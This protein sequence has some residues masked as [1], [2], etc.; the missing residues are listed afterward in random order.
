MAIEWTIVPLLHRHHLIM[1]LTPLWVSCQ[2]IVLLLPWKLWRIMKSKYYYVLDTVII[3]IIKK[4]VYICILDVQRTTPVFKE[5]MIW[6][7]TQIFGAKIIYFLGVSLLGIFAYLRLKELQ[8]A[9]YRLSSI[10]K[11]YNH[12]IFLIWI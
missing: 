3:S 5:P 2:T 4:H 6:M 9:F 7:L 1:L 8:T 12:I 10:F 11:K